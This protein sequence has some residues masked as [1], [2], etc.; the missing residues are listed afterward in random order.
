[1]AYESE[2]PYDVDALEELLDERLRA[3]GISPI[4]WRVERLAEKLGQGT[5]ERSMTFHLSDGS[6][7]RTEL[8]HRP[9]GNQ[10]LEQ[11][12]RAG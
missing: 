10:E 2:L 3:T 8:G 5:G 4:R 12:A 9:I 11:L 6:L 7:R 1:V